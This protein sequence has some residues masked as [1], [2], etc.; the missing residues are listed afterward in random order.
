MPDILGMD[1]V[2]GIVPEQG[3]QLEQGHLVALTEPGGVGN[4]RLQTG[5]TVTGIVGDV[6][7]ENAG[8]GVLIDGVVQPEGNGLTGAVRNII[9]GGLGD[10]G[11]DIIAG[12]VEDDGVIQCLQRIQLRTVSGPGF[13]VALGAVGDGFTALGDDE[14]RIET[15]QHGHNIRMGAAAEVVIKNVELPNAHIVQLG[16]LCDQ[17]AVA[18]L[19][20]GGIRGDIQ[21]AEEAAQMHAPDIVALGLLTD[22]DKLC[23]L[24]NVRLGIQVGPAAGM[25]CIGLGGV[26]IHVHLDISG[27]VHQLGTSL[28]VP[29]A[30]EAFDEATV[31]DPGVVLDLRTQQDVVVE[32]GQ[33]HLQSSH[34]EVH[35]IGILTDDGDLILLGFE[36]VAVI[37]AVE[38]IG[39]DAEG[40][41]VGIGSLAGAVHAQ[42][43]VAR[44]LHRGRHNSCLDA[45]FLQDLGKVILGRFVDSGFVHDIYLGIQ[46]KFGAVI[47]D[48]PDDGVD[49][50]SLF[51]LGLH[52]ASGWYI[53]QHHHDAE[54]QTQELLHSGHHVL[55]SFCM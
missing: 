51:L 5:D 30:V 24:L 44:T 54:D 43:N 41:L 7:Q 16:Q 12:P 13:V 31:F 45:V 32:G 1:G 9:H 11:V 38:V 55:L 18:L 33:H 22:L 6:A 40:I 20:Q 3:G 8:L 14:F 34:A 39:L 29:A 50:V 26:H 23:D 49:G 37:L 53:G 25:V 35:G 48:G 10:G 52:C 47:D 19:V 28:V 4:S 17:L 42:Q 15:V 2:V 21:A 46:C 36:H 27:E